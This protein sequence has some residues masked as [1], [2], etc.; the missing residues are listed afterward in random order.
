MTGSLLNWLSLGVEEFARWGWQQRIGWPD[1]LGSSPV[2]RYEL[3]LEEMLGE[4]ASATPQRSPAEARLLESVARTLW[5]P[6]YSAFAIRGPAG[7]EATYWV[8]LAGAED[9]I[10]LIVSTEEVRI[11]RVQPTEIAESLVAHLPKV[12]AAPTIRMEVAPQTAA[13]L[14]GGFERNAPERTLRSA[15][16]S[17]GIPDVIAARLLAPESAVLATGTIGAMS[18]ESEPPRLA[19]RSASWS[20]MADGA[21]LASQGRGGEVIWEPMSPTVMMRVVADAIASLGS[22]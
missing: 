18:Y 1:P 2:G 22:R 11:S 6:A 19:P 4:T 21:M 17:A 12:L 20:E 16:S 8:A 9:T 13:L 7:E 14:A 15:M 10:L 5:Y 3:P